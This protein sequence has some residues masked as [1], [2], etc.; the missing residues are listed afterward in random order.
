MLLS[1]MPVIELCC[2]LAQF[3]AAVSCCVFNAGQESALFL[4]RH[5][6]EIAGHSSVFLQLIQGGDAEDLRRYGQAKAKAI[7]LR[8]AKSRLGIKATLRRTATQAL[9]AQYTYFSA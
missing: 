5:R 2:A 3:I 1:V 4:D 9:H 6:L 7:T 8:C